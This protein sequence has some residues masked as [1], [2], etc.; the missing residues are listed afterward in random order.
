[1][2]LGLIVIQTQ[3]IWNVG[4]NLSSQKFAQRLG[5]PN[6][7][8]NRKVPT[9]E[10]SNHFDLSQADF[11]RFH[12]LLISCNILQHLTTFHEGQNVKTS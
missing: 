3:H 8:K 4:A 5:K 9:K 11:V 10:S 6:Q 12:S 7:R 2:R 1:L